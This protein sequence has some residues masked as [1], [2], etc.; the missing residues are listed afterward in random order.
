MLAGLAVSAAVVVPSAAFAEPGGQPTTNC[1][2]WSYSNQFI[3]QACTTRDP[4]TWTISHF[5]QWEYIGSGVAAADITVTYYINYS[6]GSCGSSS[7]F[8]DSGQ[9]YELGCTTQ[10]VQ[11]YDY[12]TSASIGGDGWVT[13]TGSA[14]S[15]VTG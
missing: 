3:F 1:T 8:M 5:G 13:S 10:R 11:G 7:I 4:S 12:G 2:G 14:G 15:H 9:I 6:G